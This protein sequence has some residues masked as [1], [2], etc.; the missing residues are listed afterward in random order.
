MTE[1]DIIQRMIYRLGQSQDDRPSEE[2]RAHFADVD[3]RTVE[4]LLLFVQK[5]AAHVNHYHR[6]PPKDSEPPG[7]W[8]SFFP[9]DETTVKELVES[10]NGKVSPHLALI[11]AFLELYKQ[12][13]K[14]INRFTRRHLDFYYSDILRLSKKSAVSDKAHV[15]LELKRNVSPVTIGPVNPLSAGK[16]NKG[17]ELVYVPT[18][19]TVINPAKVESLR[20]IF[21]DIGDHG[22]I[23]YAPVA[24]SS[25]GTGGALDEDE[26]RWYGFGHEG[27]PPAEVGFAL[28]SPVLRM[29]EGSR[30]V[31]AT[32]TVD[33]ADKLSSTSPAF[34]AFITGEKAWL[35]PWNIP[36]KQSGNKLEF[37]LTI[38]ES[39]PA[40]TDYNATVH[41]YSYT[42][43]AP[44]LQ[45]LLRSGGDLGYHDF[46]DMKV[47]TATVKINVSGVTS[48]NLESDGGTLD[49]KKAFLP[50]GP[51]P[52][53][54]SRFMV[55]CA[56]AL[57][58]KL[59]M[60]KIK[61]QWKEAPSNFSNYYRDYGESG[62]DN[63]YFR[64]SVSFEDGGNWR[65]TETGV[66]L[67]DPRNESNEH[68]FEFPAPAISAS[69]PYSA[70][71][72]SSIS[73]T[74]VEGMKLRSL[75]NSGSLWASRAVTKYI[76]QRPVLKPYQG[77]APEPLAGF[78]TF[79]L[80]T[81][82]FHNAYRIKYVENVMKYSKEGG[83]LTL[84]NEP[85]TPAIQSISLSY[86]AYSDEVDI[87]SSLL[88]DFSN[89][90]VQFFHVA[91]FGQMREHGYQRQQFSFLT[92][93]S[94]PLLPHYENEGELFIGFKDLQAS[95]SV[96]VLFQVAEGS[97]NPELRQQ[98]IRWSVL[99]D[100]YW[101]SLGTNEVVRD[102]TNQ[103]LTSGIINFVIPSEVTATNTIMPAGLIWLKGAVAKHV[104]ALCQLIDVSANA[105]EVQFTDQGND[106]L[107][108]QAALE[109]NRITKFKNGVSSIKSVK[110]PFASFGGGPEETGEAFAT[111][112]SERL[113]HKNRC[114]T[115][116]DYERIVL[117]AF[118]RVHKVKCIPHAREGAWLAPGNVLL[119]VIPDL[120][121]KNAVN[122]LEPKVDADTIS[123]ITSYVQKRAAT[124]V[125]VKVKNPNYQKIRLDFKV[126]FLTSYEFNYYS[127]ELKR[128]LVQ[129]LSPWAY[130]GGKSHDIS[131]GEKVY[132][133][134]LLDFIEDLKYVDYVEDFKMYSYT[135]EANTYVDRNEVQPET[136]DT[137][138]VSDN[139]HTI[140]EAK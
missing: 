38:P 32:L 21:L 7:N 39:E 22:T 135:G 1:K 43:Q 88:A 20:S 53:K 105:V 61:V 102:T 30:K 140:N 60:V 65:Y 58:K 8:T 93:K 101:K 103:L 69:M 64:T 83:T 18:G 112:A 40:V 56:E 122:S 9:Y 109:K 126:K 91:Y 14:L 48:L 54:G 37:V 89:D 110:Q 36:V 41:G 23:R 51:Q 59:S 42:A 13:Q 15:L 124:H 68:T 90:D 12:P 107:H 2:L 34:E 98:D 129:F 87:A 132:K 138:L 76:R 25:D 52:A 111:R 80:E 106:P 66:K 100:N 92:D 47:Q 78:I 116:W 46:K 123:R 62:I 127:T 81:G 115:A 4:Q 95:D 137:I 96:S 44:V 84:L 120:K 77:T 72:L 114:I 118:P 97:A 133:S 94:V 33:K 125:N 19:E 31:T 24:N 99:C 74:Q 121:N 5:L 131:F 130:G 57:A 50:F 71:R 73:P 63:K 108:L 86:D 55:G 70:S 67:F 35:G 79:T 28:A 104:D 49:P 16:D 10:S 85:Y 17:V 128:E 27:L 29:K 139:T 119:V 82:F 11:I 117:E 45:L 3:N 136:P 75:A 134:V 6:Y 113:R 26:P